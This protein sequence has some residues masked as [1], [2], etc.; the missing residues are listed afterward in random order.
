MFFRQLLNDES[1]CASYLLDCATYGRFAVID[2]HVD[3][4][5]NYI[6]LMRDIRPAPELQTAIVAANRSGRPLAEVP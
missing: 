1:A 4:L 3:L 5:Y 6:A 2:P